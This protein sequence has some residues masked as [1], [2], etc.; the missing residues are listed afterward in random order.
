MI[1]EYDEDEYISP[2]VYEYGMD[3]I[4]CRLFTNLV[5]TVP[6]ETTHLAHKESEMLSLF[7]FPWKFETGYWHCTILLYN[8]I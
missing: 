7:S 1:Y 3:N 4:S 6:Q 2:V 8:R 5:M